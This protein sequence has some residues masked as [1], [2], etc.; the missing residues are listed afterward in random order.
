[1][2]K[3]RS[4]SAMVLEGC[5]NALLADVLATD[6]APAEF[7][8]AERSEAHR[9]KR[10]A[11]RSAAGGGGGDRPKAGMPRR[12]RRVKLGCVQARMR[13]STE[14]IHCLGRRESV[15]CTYGI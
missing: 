7:S 5:T 12:R 1:M 3:F 9:A 2:K 15:L 6:K 11:A 14:R 8:L 4:K 13:S 10:G